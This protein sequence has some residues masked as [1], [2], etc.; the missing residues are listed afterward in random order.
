M[1]VVRASDM[2]DLRWG[3]TYDD[4]LRRGYEMG[5]FDW[6]PEVYLERIR[7]EIPG[8]DE[9]QDAGRR[10]DPVRA[11]ARAGARHGHRGDDPAPDRGP[12]RRLGDRPRLQPRHGLPRPRDLRRR[13]AR[14]HGGPAA[15]RPLGPGHLACSRSTSSTTSRSRTSAAASRASPAPWSSATSSVGRPA[16]P[17][18]ECELVLEAEIV[19]Q[20]DDLAVVRATLTERSTLA[21]TIPRPM[22]VP[23][24]RTSSARRDKRRANHKAGKATPEQLPALPQPAPAAPGLPDLR[25]LR[26]AARSSRTKS[27]RPRRP[28]PTPSSRG[29]RARRH[30]R[31]RRLRRRAGLR[32]ARRGR[33][34]GRRRRHRR[35]RLRPA[36]RRSAST[37]SRGSRSSRPRSGSA[38]R[39][40][41]SPRCAP[42]RRPRSCAPPATS[43][44]ARADAMV[45]LGSTGAT[46][47][48]A[49]FGLRRLKGVQRP[50]LAVQLPVPGKPVLFLDV[51]AN[52]EVR[53]QHLVQFAFLG[54][55]FS[56]AVLGVER[57]D[58]SACSRSARR[59]ARGARR[60]SRPTA[61][62][63]AA[64][65][66]R[67]RRQR[68]GP[69]PAGRRRPTS[70]SPTASPAT[71][72]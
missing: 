46:M 21:A 18:L 24:K 3:R 63:A 9:L 26:R 14:P 39:R 51:G 65:R 70:S 40:T 43:P 44:R 2:S 72:P 23:K 49:T 35:P 16:R 52:V 42:S 11:R 55:A 54:A 56:A 12:P 33:A 7:A 34:A 6:T 30:R 58:A 67:V 31:P 47:A 68:R 66:D 45:S 36:A 41:R 27:P 60:W 8:Y 62:L 38:T 53:A 50:A 25:H 1:M 15:R 64:P 4:S 17:D 13:A 10:G 37:A 59:P 48:A 5:Q 32:R 20:Q 69:R 57:P 28:P 22:A 29:A 71:S 61:L 19:W